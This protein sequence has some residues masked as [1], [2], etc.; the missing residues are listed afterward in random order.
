MVQDALRSDTTLR[1]CIHNIYIM[2][3]DGVII[4][5]GSVPDE[6]LRLGARKIASE[7]EGVKLLIEDIKIGPIPQRRVEV[8]IDWANGHIGV[9]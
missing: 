3:N 5:V 7:V 1:D 2:E 6:R 8:H 4:M 9:Y